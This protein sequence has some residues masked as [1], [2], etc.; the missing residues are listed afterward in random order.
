MTRY[1][2]LIPVLFLLTA[3]QAFARPV[4][5]PTGWTVIT[6]HDAVENSALV[7]Y[8]FT[9]EI[10]VGYRYAYDRATQD[11]FHGVQM[12][13]LLKRWNNPDSQANV[14]L[15]SAIGVIDGHDGFAGEGFTGM[16]ADWENR[17]IMVM[18]EN[19]AT[20]SS[21]GDRSRFMQD[22]GFGVAPYVADFGALHSWAMFHIVHQP[23]HDKPVQ[24]EPMLRFFKGQVMVETG[25]NFTVKRPVINATFR[26]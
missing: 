23:D 14:Y 6:E 11:G 12:N 13:N 22:V 26:F 5:Y 19:R 9:P 25:Y 4:S 16:Q 18:Y 2:F 20:L 21:E 24:F 15:K 3:P 8:T 7:H 10:P 1:V 17:R